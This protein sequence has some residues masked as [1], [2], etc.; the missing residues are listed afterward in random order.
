MRSG[1]KWTKWAVAAVLVC[2]LLAS[3]A[4]AGT[5]FGHRGKRVLTGIGNVWDTLPYGKSRTLLVGGTGDEY[6]ITRLRANGSID[7]DFG[8]DGRVEIASEHVA[9]QSD[10]RILVLSTLESADRSESDPLLTRLL[11]DGE[12]DRSFGQR[13]QLRVDLGNRFDTGAA[14]ALLPGGKIAIAGMS[15]GQIEPRAGVISGDT[16]VARLLSG[17]SFDPGFGN[18]GRTTVADAR[19]PIALEAGPRD[20]LYLQDGSSYRR[21]IRLDSSGALDGSFGLQGTVVIPFTVD[22]PETF[23]LTEGDFAVLPDG[24]VLIG[25]TLA[26]GANHYEHNLVGVLRLSPDGSPDPRFGDGGFARVGFPHGATF[27][28]GLAAT[29]EGRSVIVCTTQ[30]P[31]G[32]NSQLSAIALT[33]RGKLDRRF[34]DGGR[35]RIGFRGWMVGEDL[36]LRRGFAYLVGGARGPETLV[37]R[38]PLNRRR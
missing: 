24:G 6:T 10:G 17:G 38:A 13:G 1:R 11:P 35:M 29:R 25:G 20:T 27:A 26:S 5:H 34:G 37:A 7:P 31:F 14:L 22:P 2:G 32:A 30:I 16:V 23:F 3:S 33:P 12:V 18:G 19:E 15:G 8:R 4:L 9:V 21:L 36:F 28:G